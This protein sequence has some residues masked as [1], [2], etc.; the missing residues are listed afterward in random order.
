MPWFVIVYTALVFFLGMLYGGNDVLGW[1]QYLSVKHG[2]AQY[3]TKT[4]EFMWK[5][6]QK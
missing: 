6:E 1:Y 3:D 2:C 5:E 4:G